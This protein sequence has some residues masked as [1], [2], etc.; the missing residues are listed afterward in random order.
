MLWLTLLLPKGY[1]QSK[2]TPTRQGK[3]DFVYVLWGQDVR[4]YRVRRNGTLQSV[5]QEHLEIGQYPRFL[6]ASPNGHALYVGS[7]ARPNDYHSGVIFEFTIHKN[8][9][10]SRLGA[11]EAGIYPLLMAI[12]PS[13]SFLYCA[14]ENNGVAS[15]GV[16][17]QYRV[18]PDGMLVPL[19][20]ALVNLNTSF[21]GSL[22]MHPSGKYLYTLIKGDP[23]CFRI[24]RNGTLLRL[25]SAPIQSDVKELAIDPSGRYVYLLQKD[26]VISVA[27]VDL[28][29]GNLSILRPVAHVSRGA[30]N[31]A[32]NPE[33]N[34]LHIIN[35]T[36]GMVSEFHIAPDGSL[37]P[38][39]PPTFPALRAF[40]RLA[41]DP[42]G[43]FAYVTHSR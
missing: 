6:A 43:Q 32:I 27:N 36:G 16:I 3:Q 34:V 9:S 38:S 13:R 5:P 11:V 17:Y 39:V 1:S 14:A 31:M 2:H 7:D 20:P 19:T 18:K 41:V 21:A 28:H 30:Y 4:V 42:K 22:N 8:G 35:P 37:K 26:S 25:P 40:R 15:Q 23:I 33:Q 12:S 10:L 24:S 29:T